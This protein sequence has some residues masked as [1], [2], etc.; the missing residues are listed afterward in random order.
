MKQSE[1]SDKPWHA[2]PAEDALNYWESDLERGLSREQAED[3]LE[4]IGQNALPLAP[5]ANLFIR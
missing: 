1:F 4:R 5:R 3:R 2:L